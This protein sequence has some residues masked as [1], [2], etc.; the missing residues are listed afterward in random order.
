MPRIAVPEGISTKVFILDDDALPQIPALLDEMWPGKSAWIVADGNTW[1]AA[2]ERVYRILEETGR[3]CCKPCILPAVP[4]PHPDYTLACQLAEMMPD[5]A[6]P[7]AVGSGVINDLIKTAAGIRKVSY[8]CIPTAP[9]VDGYTSKGSALSVG[10]SKKT[11]PCPAPAAVVADRNVLLTAPPEMAAAGY[12]DLAAK[13]VAGA[14]WLIA[15]ALK[16]DPVRPEIWNIV[17]K[18]L[19]AWLADPADLKAIFMGLA[20]TGY[21]MQQHNDSRPASGAEHLFSHVLEMEH[22][23]YNGEEVSHGFKVSVGSVISLRLMQFF[24]AT[25]LEEARRLAEPPLTVDARKKEIAELLKRRCYGED[26]ARLSMEKFQAGD[27][28]FVRRKEIYAV[29]NS[30]QEKVARQL[31]DQEAFVKSLKDAGCPTTPEEIGLDRE[32]S[33]HGIFTAQLIRRRY[34]IL[35]LLYDAGLLKTAVEKMF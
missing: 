30:L 26:P 7:L 8:C 25:T 31:G 27:A 2:G 6:V 16:Q 18:D 35:D 17:Q 9:S 32:Q 34:N 28:A 24:L 33:I 14:D 11:V 3:P 12:G 21:A 10:G 23:K 4:K 20:A 13:I 5:N 19:R 22:L 15:D 29:W 1:R